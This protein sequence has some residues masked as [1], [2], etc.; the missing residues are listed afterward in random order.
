MRLCADRRCPVGSQ[1]RAWAGCLDTSAHKYKSV[2]VTG[3]AYY[4]P[5]SFN[6]QSHGP[7]ASSPTALDD[8]KEVAVGP[9]AHQRHQGTSS[10]HSTR[11]GDV[12]QRIM[13]HEAR[14]YTVRRRDTKMKH[15]NEAGEDEETRHRDSVL[16][17]I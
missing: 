1:V 13:G 16:T 14:C 5:H 9:E 8:L 11:S 7:L 10:A 3:C 15:G 4:E 6:E 12:E 17:I 2:A